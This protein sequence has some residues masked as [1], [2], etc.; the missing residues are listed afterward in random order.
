MGDSDPV[1]LF[2]YVL[3]QLSKRGIAYAH[4][5]EP[6]VGDAAA[7]VPLDHSAPRTAEIFRQA[8]NGVLISAGGYTGATA[9]AAIAAGAADAVA[10]G[11]QFIAN[12]DLPDRL[13]AGAPLNKADRSTFYGGDERGYT[14]YPSLQLQ[15][16]LS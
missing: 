12:P 4:V 9:E 5:I 15:E 11:R 6:R 7:D 3:E 8:F 2:T 10:F 14:D 16:E 13:R 1:T